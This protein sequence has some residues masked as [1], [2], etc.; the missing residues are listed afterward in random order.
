MY[1]SVSVLHCEFNDVELRFLLL[2]SV[3]NSMQDRFLPE[4]CSNNLQALQQVLLQIGGFGQKSSTDLPASGWRHVASSSGLSI[5]KGFLT[6]GFT[7]RHLNLDR[8][9][10]FWV[11]ATEGTNREP[12]RSVLWTCR[13]AEPRAE[14]CRGEAGWAQR[15]SAGPGLLLQCCRKGTVL[16]VWSPLSNCQRERGGES[17]NTT[18]NVNFHN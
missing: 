3:S 16:D 13:G 15:C 11:R 2:W 5:L 18:M 12:H 17:E 6:F 14:L 4:K 8:A 1:C 9:S 10:H 7:L